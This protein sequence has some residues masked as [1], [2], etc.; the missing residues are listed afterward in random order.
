MLSHKVKHFICY[1]CFQTVPNESEKIDVRPLNMLF[2]G[3]SKTPT[4]SCTRRKIDVVDQVETPSMRNH[5]K[6]LLTIA[7][8]D[9]IGWKLAGDR[10]IPD[11]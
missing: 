9:K 1:V 3:K 11:S 6:F 4:G 10:I 7:E 8:W 2:V 5:I